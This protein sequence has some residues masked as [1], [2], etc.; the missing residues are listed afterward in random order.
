MAAKGNDTNKKYS[1]LIQT[2]KD[3]VNG[4]S[5]TFAEQ[6]NYAGVNVT[7]KINVDA[8]VHHLITKETDV[9]NPDAVEVYPISKLMSY[10]IT[11]PSEVIEKKLS[12]NPI[13]PVRETPPPAKL[14]VSEQMKTIITRVDQVGFDTP[15]LSN[16]LKEISNNTKTPTTSKKVWYKSTLTGRSYPSRALM[17]AFDNVQ[18]IRDSR[19][20]SFGNVRLKN[21]L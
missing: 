19:G 6:E 4:Y 10:T 1:A 13:Q 5:S 18:R 16:D 9:N 20:I 12:K 2:V 7:H 17:D 14:P 3:S 8:F 11:K 15:P 21:I